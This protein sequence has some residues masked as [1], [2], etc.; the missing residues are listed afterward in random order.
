MA[1][2]KP[3][4]QCVPPVLSPECTTALPSDLGSLT[5]N[6]ITTQAPS[7]APPPAVAMDKDKTMYVDDPRWQGEYITSGK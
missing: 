6:L 3:P 4:G 1:Q 7:V 2:T 5:A